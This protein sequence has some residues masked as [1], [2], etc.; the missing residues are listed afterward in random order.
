MEDLG[1]IMLFVGM[2]FVLLITFSIFGYKQA[3]VLSPYKPYQAVRPTTIDD[4]VE[5]YDSIIHCTQNKI[6]TKPYVLVTM[7]EDG[8]WAT[9]AI[10]KYIDYGTYREIDSVKCIR[11]KQMQ[12]K[13][14]QLEKLNEKSCK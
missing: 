5:V 9:K 7:S 14:Y 11:Y 3:N 12:W 1:K 13:M 6:V 4:S 8:G 2:L 10:Y